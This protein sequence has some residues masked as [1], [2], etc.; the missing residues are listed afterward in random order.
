M[1]QAE[2]EPVSL[3]TI[4][5][6]TH[7]KPKEFEQPY[8]D[9]LSGFKAW[10][11]PEHAEDGIRFPKNLGPPLSFDEVAVTHGELGTPLTN[12]AQHGK[13]G[14]LVAMIQGTTAREIAHV[15]EKLSDG[16]R[17]TVTEVTREMAANMEVAVKQALP[18]AKLVTDRF[19]GQQRL[20]E[21]GQ[22]IRLEL[23]RAA[24]KAENEQIPHA[25][26]A[27][28]PYTPGMD[29]NGDTTKQLLARSRYLLCN[30]PQHMARP[31]E[32]ASG[33]SFSGIFAA[34]ARRRPVNDVS[35]VLG[36]QYQHC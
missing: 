5:P 18:R 3:A 24:L 12:K 6:A 13:K 36:I 16:A 34:Q 14:A 32:G 1:H 29:E 15:F 19:Q 20:S 25:R 26:Q 27:G 4:A 17:H 7:L 28:T 22:D 30:P 35:L 21:A 11:Q 2:T 23:R 8:N 9:P 33:Y 10:E 31:T